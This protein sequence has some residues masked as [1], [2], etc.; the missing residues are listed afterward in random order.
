MSQ[1]AKAKEHLME[2]S[3]S[4]DQPAASSRTPSQSGCPL[5]EAPPYD[6]TATRKGEGPGEGKS[7]EAV[8][9]WLS[10]F[11]L[12]VYAPNFLSA[13]YD[14]P[15][16]SRMTPENGYENI[17]FITDITWEDLQEIGIIKL[18]HQKKL[19]LAVKRLAEMQ[20]GSD[21]LMSPKMS[22]FQDSE[23]SPELQSA[24]MTQP[25]QEEEEKEEKEEE[26]EEEEKEEEKEEEELLDLHR[27]RRLGLCASRAAR[28]VEAAF[29][30]RG[31]TVT[32]TP[33]P[34]LRLPTR[35]L[36]PPQAQD[37]LFLL[38]LLLRPHSFSADKTQ[39][40]ASVHPGRETPVS[41]IKPPSVSNPTRASDN[42]DSPPDNS[43]LQT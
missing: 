39:A 26:E 38:L 23:L 13:G 4:V 8:V 41:S 35:L 11:Q 2:Q 25:G 16:I 6:A 3:K 17:E 12:Q 43:S 37:L 31:N 34:C 29:P 10:D 14:L 33:T 1:S 20:R 7:S 36:T 30:L 21:E 32:P 18:G 42:P 15:T 28:G 40:H 9:Q 5:H 22:S 24:I 19:M 27:K